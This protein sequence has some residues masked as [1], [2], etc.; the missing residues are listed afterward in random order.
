MFRKVLFSATS[1]FF[2]TC[3]ASAL[4]LDGHGHAKEKIGASL[5]K[6]EALALSDIPAQAF[7][8][9]KAIEAKFIPKEVEKEY[10]NGNEYLD[11]EGE[12][13]GQEIEFDMLKTDAGWKVVEIQRDITWEQLPK[14][15]ASELKAK[16]ASVKPK[17]II[18][19]K[20][21]G[22]NLTVFELYSVDEK[23]KESKLEVKLQNG[24]ATILD[25]EWT[26]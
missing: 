12:V 20:Q 15:V 19:S 13:N 3:A 8:E 6:K 14:P 16:A 11:L 23:G 7:A 10:K 25:K 22:K 2:I 4:A 5:H 1:I 9:V 21:Y 18:E 24:I 17:R 26:H